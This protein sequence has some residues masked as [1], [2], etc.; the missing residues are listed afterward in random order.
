MVGL[1]EGDGIIFVPK[2]LKHN[3]HQGVEPINYDDD[4]DADDEYDDDDFGDDNDDAMFSSSQ[5]TPNI[6]S[7]R[8]GQ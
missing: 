2:D 4:D 3:Q 1:E 5:W 7:T 6:I 8:G